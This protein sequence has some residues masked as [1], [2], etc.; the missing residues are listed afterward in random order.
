LKDPYIFDFIDTTSILK[1]RE[2][3]REMVAHVGRLLLELGAGFA[4]I[5][6]QY[7]I[8]VDDQDFYIDLLFYNIKLRCFVVVEL[9]GTDFQPDYAGQI[10]FY[11]TAVDELLRHANDNPTIGILLCRGKSG[12]VADYALRGL[13]KPIGVAEYRLVRDLPLELVDLLP[14]A[15][16]IANRL[17]VPE[18]P[19]EYG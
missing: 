10:S 4:F 7:H 8:V 9:K 5:G 12:L 18:E 19:D 13:D 3:E 16:D 15:D 14:S 11:V 1:E 17:N 6:Q 2:I